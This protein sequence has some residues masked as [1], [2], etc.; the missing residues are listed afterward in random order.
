MKHPI[1][2]FLSLGASFFIISPAFCINSLQDTHRAAQYFM[3]EL[4][5]TTNVVEVKSV[6]EGKKEKS[7]VIVD[8]RAAKDFAEGHIPGA[9]N[10]PYTDYASF[11]GSEKEFPGLKKDQLN[12]VY[13]YE[14]LCNL[15]QKACKKFAS[16]GYPVKDIKGGF[17]SWKEHDYPIEK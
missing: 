2:A 3:D 13:C 1:L 14:L 10:L 4:N 12:Y 8:T 17:K 16:L 15:S 6:I 5:Y 11:E 7:A 9:I